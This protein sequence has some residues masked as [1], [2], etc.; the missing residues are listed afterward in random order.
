MRDIFLLIQLGFWYFPVT[1]VNL[2]K[3]LIYVTTRANIGDSMLFVVAFFCKYCCKAS[4]TA[5]KR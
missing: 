3:V 5:E 1:S 4:Q 2:Q